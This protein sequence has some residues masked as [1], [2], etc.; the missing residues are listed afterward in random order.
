MRV[1]QILLVMVLLFGAGGCGQATVAP[2]T[3]SRGASLVLTPRLADPSF[4]TQAVVAQYTRADIRHLV[5]RL[6][7]W[8]GVTETPVADAYG[9]ELVLDLVKSELDS[10]ITIAH[11]RGNTTY[12]IRAYA[13]KAAGTAA[14][15][16]IST[17]D[18]TSYTDVVVS[19]DDTPTVSTFRVRLLP[20]S[21]GASTRIAVS[22]TGSVRF[23]SVTYGLYGPASSGSPLVATAS[24]TVTDL[25]NTLSFS[26]LQAQS[27]YRLEA[28]AVDSA[29]SAIAAATG[30]VAIVVSD[31]TDVAT[32]SLVLSIPL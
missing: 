13:Y 17:S 21:F 5:L 3:A 31:D 15:D 27:T 30:S 24:L 16:L 8:D 1:F 10:P 28:Q 11:L 20:T 19:N 25:P 7:T 22:T 32:S 2:P 12:R 29:G 4:E 14:S 18:A 9:S 6:Y 26:N 23:S